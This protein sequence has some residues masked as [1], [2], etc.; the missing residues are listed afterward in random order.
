M[1]TR[2]SLAASVLFLVVSACGD[3]AGPA[4]TS[5]A[6]QSFRDQT[7]ACGAE[8]PPDARETTFSHPDALDL[9]DVVTA[10]IHTSCGDVTIDLHPEIAP[11]AVASFVFLAEQG[12]FD[13]TV[14]HRIVPGYIVQF[15]D[16]TATGRGGPGY[17][18]PDEL[19]ADGFA[20][21]S[22]VVAMANSGP[23]SAGSQFFIALGNTG[24]DPDYT[25][26]GVV[27]EG[28]EALNAIQ[29]V[30]IGMQPGGLEPSKPLETVY[31]ES[32]DIER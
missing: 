2:L 25:V 14:T 28:A 10:V 26:F 30:P 7:T 15:G 16:P 5:P 27:T 4:I 23:D 22:G 6:Y 31:I 19:P 12:Y 18:L 20:Y 11:L 1:H 21:Q 13:G 29:S 3:D 32:I 8:R 17:T 24:L 9:P